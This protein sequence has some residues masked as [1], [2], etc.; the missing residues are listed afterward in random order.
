MQAAMQS[1]GVAFSDPQS[2]KVSFS[3]VKLLELQRVLAGVAE[4]GNE[5]KVRAAL[6]TELLGLTALSWHGWL[7]TRLV[8]TA[9]WSRSPC[10]VV[11]GSTK[12]S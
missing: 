12:V 1:A 6:A 9:G 3:R 4:P 10:T 2:M 7:R 5:G 8:G 11:F